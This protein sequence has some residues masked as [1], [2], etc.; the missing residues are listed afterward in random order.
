MLGHVLRRVLVASA[1]AAG[2][3]SVSLVAMPASAVPTVTCSPDYPDQVVT[4]TSLSLGTPV[5]RF[6]YYNHAY[7]EVSSGAGTPGGTVQ[8]RVDD[9]VYTLKLKGGTAKHPLPRTLS[10]Q[11]THT[12][13]ASYAGAGCYKASSDSESYTVYRA[14]ASVRGLD[15]DDIRSGHRPSVSGHVTTDTG[16]TPGGTIEVGLYR[17]G[18]LKRSTTTRLDDGAFDVD[19]GRVYRKGVWTAQAKVQGNSN[20]FGDTKRTSFRVR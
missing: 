18:D 17:N 3:L 14:I 4:T 13:T 20:H 2:A 15:A 1:T 16:V 8:L 11:T 7:V 10:A 9:D 6:G 5:G 19:F 12:V